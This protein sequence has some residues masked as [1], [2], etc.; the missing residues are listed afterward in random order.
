MRG[1]LAAVCI[2]VLIAAAVPAG[3]EDFQPT[4]EPLQNVSGS[5]AL[6]TRFT[7]AEG[8]WPGLVRR[9]Y[10]A[11]A[12]TNGVIGY[13]FDIDPSTWGGAFVLGDVADQTGEGN[14]DVFFYETMAD[15]GGQNAP[16]TVA[17][18]QTSNKGEIG[19]VPATA[20]KAIVFTPNAVRATF[21]YKAYAPEVV[22]LGVESLDVT[23][24]A[25]ATVNWLNSTGDYSYVRHLPTR[26][27]ALFDSSPKAGT[28]IRVGD[29]FSYIFEEPGTYAY[30][31]SVGDGTITVTDGPGVGYPTA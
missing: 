14:L 1:S 13:V 8:G 26:G 23:V 19:Y 7:D 11:H 28:G 25:G 5:I 29:T 30:T 17:E 20:K 15:A 4:G 3:A 12:G 31:T 10:Q 16:V 6:P 18:Y 21:T 22:E 27:S 24:P 9:V 2:A